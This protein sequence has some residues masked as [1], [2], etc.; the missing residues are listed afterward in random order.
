MLRI[1]CFYLLLLMS[2]TNSQG[3][4]YTHQEKAILHFKNHHYKKIHKLF[5]E[6]LKKKINPS[7]LKKIWIELEKGFGKYKSHGIT[8]LSKTKETDKYSTILYFKNGSLLLETG[9]DEKG[10]I[11]GI[12]FKPKSY[13]LPEYGKNLVYSKED[14]TIKTGKYHLPGEIIYPK[15]L[16]KKVPLVI[17]VHGSGNNDRYENTGPVSVF[18]DMLLGLH[19]LGIASLVYD[20][21]TLIYEKEYDSIQF[22][23][24][25]ETINDAVSAYKLAKTRPDIDTNQIFILGHSLGGYALPLIL[26]NCPGVKGGIS[27]AGCA[28]PI[29]DLLVYQYKFLTELDGKVT[30]REKIFLRKANKKIKFV[31]SEKL[32]TSK[33]QINLLAYWPSEFWKDVKNYRPVEEVEKLKEPVLFLQ[34]DR[35]YQVTNVDFELWKS[36]YLSKMNASFISYDKLNHLFIEGNGKPNPAEYWNGGNVPIYVM[37]D[38]ADWIKSLPN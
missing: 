28:R 2:L 21:R 29:D 15:D 9:L 16:S 38:I 1:I 34:G 5:D 26:K 33:P 27:L 4:N 30:L 24:W 12:F 36:I 20:K 13:G 23:L 31:R 7:D 32:F 25:D 18:K 10:K 3:Q 17:F 8:T 14:I 19:N 11:N 37:E 6:D 22:T 35:D